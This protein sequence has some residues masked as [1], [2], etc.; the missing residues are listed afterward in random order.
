MAAALTMIC[1]LQK[2]YGKTIEELEALVDGFCWALEDYSMAEIMWGLKKY[3]LE[4]ADIPAPAEIKK[5][6]DSKP[7]EGEALIIQK[8]GRYNFHRR[9]GLFL[10]PHESRFL[11]NYEK[12]KGTVWWQN[13]DEW[14]KGIK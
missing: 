12:Q 10:S 9:Q 7:L 8:V 2:T 3:I 1:Q 11:E 13:Y 14:R 4:N 6:I 5:I